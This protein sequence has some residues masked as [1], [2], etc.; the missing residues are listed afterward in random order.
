MLELVE[1]TLGSPLQHSL[2]RMPLRAAVEAVEQEP[3]HLVVQ[4]DQR[5]ACL[6]VAVVELPRLL[7]A[8]AR[9]EVLVQVRHQVVD[10]VVE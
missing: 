5:Q 8:L 9:L 2:L 4:A 6:P 7:V 1:Q 10:Q 3:L